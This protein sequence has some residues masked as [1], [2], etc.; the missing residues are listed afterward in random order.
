MRECIEMIR[1]CRN[2]SLICLF[3]LYAATVNLEA[4]FI[5]LDSVWVSNAFFV[6]LFG[7]IFASIITVGICELKKYLIIKSNTENHLFYQGF[8]LYQALIQLKQ[9]IE[10]YLKNPKWIISDN[11]FD[12]NMRMIQCEV[13]SIRGTEY[14][15]FRE[16]QDAIHERFRWKCLPDMLFLKSGTKLKIAIGEERIKCL[17]NHRVAS[18]NFTSSNPQIA[19]TLYDVLEKTNYYAIMVDNYISTF[20]NYCDN[21]F[22]YEKLK[23]NM[24]IPHIK[25]QFV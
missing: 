21:R 13:A 3:L 9:N 5:G 12:E 1:F 6:N 16:K 22:E 17:Q 25:M 14:I 4:N 20:N 10:D 2:I 19:Y 7:G 23:N 24:E 8:Y 18:V 15:T 11:L